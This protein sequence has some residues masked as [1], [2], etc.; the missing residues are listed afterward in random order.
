MGLQSNFRD[1]KD[2]NFA[3]I[4]LSSLAIWSSSGEF[5]ESIDLLNKVPRALVIHAPN[6]IDGRNTK[7]RDEHPMY[8]REQIPQMRRI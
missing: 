6:R 1:A 3:K 5:I 7:N 8:L 2:G 4:C